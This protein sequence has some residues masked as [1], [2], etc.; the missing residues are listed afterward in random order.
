MLLQTKVSIPNFQNKIDYTSK[1]FSIGSCF[2]INISEKLDYYKFETIVNPIGILFHPN[3]IARF[4]ERAATEEYYQAKD[5]FYNNEQWQCF[6]A[7][8]LMN[9]TSKEAMLEG[10]NKALSTT[11][12]FIMQA[13]HCLITL[14]TAWIYQEKSTKNIVANCHKLPSTNFNKRLLRVEEI[15]Q[16]LQLIQDAVHNLNPKCCLVFSLSPVRH[17]KDGLT[18]N[19]H[20]KALLLCGMHKFLE[21]QT[22]KQTNYFPAYEIMMDE[23]RDYR[24]YADD[25]LH[26]SGIAIDYIWEQ[27]KLAA[28]S[29]TIEKTMQRV[30]SIQKRLLHR[31][32]NPASEAH[33]TFLTQL[34][35]DINQLQKDYPSFSFNT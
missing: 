30:A 28:L 31:P 6:E 22:E 7:H 4:L 1:I 13:S 8:S 18:E 20:S 11:K 23:L 14:G 26:P 10:L 34:N 29:P 9:T 5:V 21:A 2:A 12:S 16:S 27:F 32:F 17:L 19:A 3:A 15:S 33:Q 35:R 24:F 25:L